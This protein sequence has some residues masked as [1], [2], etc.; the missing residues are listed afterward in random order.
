MKCSTVVVEGETALGDTVALSS[1]NGVVPGAGRSVGLGVRFT[2]THFILFFRLRVQPRV[3]P[4][5]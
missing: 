2:V 3:Q 5:V 4:V 1:V